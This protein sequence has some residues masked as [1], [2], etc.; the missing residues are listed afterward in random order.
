M[1]REQVQALPDC[2][3]LAALEGGDADLKELVLAEIEDR[4]SD[5][6][7]RVETLK[8]D[9]GDLE[10][11]CIDAVTELQE[12]RSKHARLRAELSRAQ[13]KTTNRDVFA[14]AALAG[15][16]IKGWACNFETA[17]MAFCHADEM[18]RAGGTGE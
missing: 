18:M 11:D 10:C 12:I 6:R 1:T 4:L 16:I 7:H 9:A 15:L 13:A 2:E 17:R 8:G 3:L 5:L 14:A